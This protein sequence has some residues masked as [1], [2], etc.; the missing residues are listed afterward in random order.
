MLYKFKGHQ[1]QSQRIH[2][3]FK[4][5]SQKLRDTWDAHNVDSHCLCELAIGD[6]K[7][8]FGINKCEF[9]KFSRR[10]TNV[11]NP[12]KGGVRQQHGTTRSLGLNRGA[13]TKH[14]KYGLTYVGGTSKGKLSLHDI[15]TGKRLTQQANIKDCNILTNLRWRAQIVPLV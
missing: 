2:R 9:F 4:K 13:L 1:T 14:K 6:I 8:F 12:Q 3:G 5:T 10:Q 15:K 7:P 11:T